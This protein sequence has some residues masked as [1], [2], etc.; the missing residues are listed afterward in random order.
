MPPPWE[1]WGR[2]LGEWEEVEETEFERECMWGL[3]R[4]SKGLEAIMWR[5]TAA[6]QTVRCGYGERVR[7]VETMC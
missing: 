6:M 3:G 7:T 4:K 5:F 2:E 1:D